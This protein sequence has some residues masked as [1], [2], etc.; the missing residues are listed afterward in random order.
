[1]R[2]KNYRSGITNGDVL[3]INDLPAATVRNAR[4]LT[5]LIL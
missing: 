3:F 4:Y 1:M 2:T 5:A